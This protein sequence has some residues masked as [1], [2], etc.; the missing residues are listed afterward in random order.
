MVAS[1][2]E[3]A[4]SGAV[5]IPLCATGLGC[6]A[7]SAK[8]VADGIGEINRGNEKA[9][10]AIIAASLASGGLSAPLAKQEAAVVT[11]AIK[12]AVSNRALIAELLSVGTKIT[13]QDVVAVVRLP[14]GTIAFLERGTPKAGLGHI[15]KEHA[16]DFANIGVSQADIPAFVMYALKSGK[17]VGY[18][19]QGT[20]RSVY[21]VMLN[22]KV[23]RVA[24]TVSR[25]GFVVGANP[26]GSGPR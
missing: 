24:I 3:A 18:Q 20:G 9:G 4:K 1:A 5:T 22:G 16:G 6:M 7:V 23:Q 17:F 15:I 21:E 26:A 19:G 11:G 12:E 25:N 13:V 14:D 2:N 8:G 10:W